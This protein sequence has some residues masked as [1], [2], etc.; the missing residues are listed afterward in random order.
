M[1]AGGLEVAFFG[2]GPF[3]L[4]SLEALKNSRHRLTRVFTSPDRPRGRGLESRPSPVKAWAQAN[5]VPALSPEKP[6]TPEALAALGRPDVLVVIDYG[7]ILRRGLLEIPR[8]A[9]LN[10]HASLLPRHRGAAPV[11]W[12]LIEGDAETGVSV[13]RM[14]EKLDAGDVVAQRKREIRGSDDA[15]TLE[16]A[17]AADGAVALLEALDRLEDGTAVF[18]PQD[19]ARATTARKLTKS[20][21]RV[22]WTLSADRVLGRLRALKEWPGSHAS[23]GSSRLIL[24]EA[25]PASGSARPGEILKASPKEG[26]VVACGQGAVEITRLQAEGR[27]PLEAREFV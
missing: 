23:Y 22:D 21:G 19:P 3:G 24:L 12:A 11:Q 8:L 18:T 9:A 4:D 16:K 25:R 10:V 26:L 17:L 15:A 14:T 27:K 1:S 2:T 5:G 20:D 13:I 6:D 7:H